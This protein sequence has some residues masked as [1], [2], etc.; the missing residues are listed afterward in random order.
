[1][2]G[3]EEPMKN[4]PVFGSPCRIFEMN[5]DPINQK[6]KRILGNYELMQ[7]FISDFIYI[8]S[9]ERPEI[10]H[11]FPNR[12]LDVSY[13]GIGP[14]NR[15][16]QPDVKVP[17]MRYQKTTSSIISANKNSN[18]GV[19]ALKT[20]GNKYDVNMHNDS[21]HNKI[22]NQTLEPPQILN[23]STLLTSFN[24]AENT[25]TSFNSNP[26]KSIDLDI[27]IP[28]NKHEPTQSSLLPTT[29]LQKNKVSTNVPC[30]AEQQ[31]IKNG[32]TPITGMRNAEEIFRLTIVKSALDP[33][34]SPI[35]SP[36][37]EWKNSKQLDRSLS[38][39]ISNQPI[40]SLQTIFSEIITNLKPLSPIR[41]P[42]LKDTEN[43]GL[44][45]NTRNVELNVVKLPLVDGQ[46][47]KPKSENMKE[48]KERSILEPQYSQS[49][50]VKQNLREANESKKN[51]SV[52]SAH[53]SPTAP[54]HNG[55]I[56]Y[57]IQDINKKLHYSKSDSYSVKITTKMEKYLPSSDNIANCSLPK[58]RKKLP[59]DFTHRESDTSV[60]INESKN[61]FTNRKDDNF[62]VLPEQ[63]YSL[64]GQQVVPHVNAS[65]ENKYTKQTKDTY[66]SKIQ[67]EKNIKTIAK[68]SPLKELNY[69]YQF[70][71]GH[72]SPSREI[73]FAKTSETS[74][75]KIKFSNEKILENKFSKDNHLRQVVNKQGFV[76]PYS[77]GTYQNGLRPCINIEKDIS[78][79]LIFS[80]P[81]YKVSPFDIF[82]HRCSLLRLP[83]YSLTQRE[84]KL[85]IKIPLTLLDNKLKLKMKS[86]F[87]E[88]YKKRISHS[89]FTRKKW[90]LCIMV[91]IKTT[92]LHKIPY[93][94]IQKDIKAL[95]SELFPQKHRRINGEGLF[96]KNTHLLGSGL[97]E[98]HCFNDSSSYNARANYLKDQAKIMKPAAQKFLNLMSAMWYIMCGHRMEE[99][100]VSHNS[101]ITFFQT[102]FEFLGKIGHFDDSRMEALKLVLQTAAVHKIYLLKNFQMKQ[103][104]IDL[105]EESKTLFGKC[106]PSPQF[107]NYIQQPS[108]LSQ[109]GNVHSII[110]SRHWLSLNN[111][112]LE[113]IE[114]LVQ[115]NQ[116]WIES[117]YLMQENRDFFTIFGNKWQILSLNSYIPT[118][119]DFVKD[120][121]ELL[122]PK[123]LKIYTEFQKHI[124]FETDFI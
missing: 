71:T 15:S 72:Q 115:S 23:P 103:L 98:S 65:D 29:A 108:N 34:L 76:N 40:V 10:L 79:A 3:S 20:H 16:V 86:K 42:K 111:D 83:I 45:P 87:D 104:K 63:K 109:N 14:F 49:S 46:N 102:T 112:Y 88:N 50:V 36:I 27:E 53:T 1:M 73:F 124:Q 19:H 24:Q 59:Q 77:A 64:T 61:G 44:G 8:S 110:V 43:N 54:I 48:W 66:I 91:K 6:C 113:I 33:P 118:V 82:N 26:V 122:Q 62:N 7:T 95:R 101:V 99:E 56:K 47:I 31:E 60:V 18:S 11:N 74:P 84:R 69:K 52:I 106:F 57:G 9:Q 12:R 100:Q 2:A 13:R 94:C 17:P 4:L 105:T 32:Q 114:L 37:N 92:L 55:E 78:A 107:S 93:C 80:S 121:L 81:K 25:S 70:K 85:V 22:H 39:P 51:T 30:K 89:Y 21:N 58:E 97:L 123:E 68:E 35:S 116:F 75:L 96:N 119:V 117:Q 90:N 28:T 38:R 120:C 5:E 67:D 41:S